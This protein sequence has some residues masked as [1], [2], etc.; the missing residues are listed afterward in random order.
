V[1][2][3]KAAVIGC[4]GAGRAVAAALQQSGIDVT[5][6]N[7]GKE[8]GDR[9]TQLLGLPFVL[10][11]EFQAQGFTLL[12]NATPI[13]REDEALPFAIDSLSR[14]TVVV[15]LA[16]GTRPTPLVSGIHTRGGTVIDGYD[17]VLTQVRKQFE[18]MVGMEMPRSVGRDAVMSGT[19]GSTITPL[20]PIEIEQEFFEMQPMRSTCGT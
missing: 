10:L 9:A 4:G 12:V 20:Q 6:V 2:Q 3:R 15:D 16:Y 7:R 14:D 11:S 1:A 5:L 8:R 18:M 13:G 17:V 19:S